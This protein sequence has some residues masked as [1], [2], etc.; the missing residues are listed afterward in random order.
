[1]LGSPSTAST[2]RAVESTRERGQSGTATD[3]TGI[4]RHRV[5]LFCVALLVCCT[6]L[7]VAPAEIATAD[8]DEHE[9]EYVVV[10]LADEHVVTESAADELP[11]G[12]S[13]H[14]TVGDSTER[15]VV[16]D[17]RVVTDQSGNEVRVG[18][19]TVRTVS[20]DPNLVV[21][22]DDV[23]NDTIRVNPSSGVVETVEGNSTVT[24]GGVEI[25]YTDYDE[26]YFVPEIESSDVNRPGEGENL[27]ATVDV[28]NWGYANGTKDV[29]LELF[30]GNNDLLG[31]VTEEIELD[32]GESTTQT[33]EY[34]T[35]RGDHEADEVIVSADG[36][37]SAT[38]DIDEA[39]TVVTILE[40][41]Q[42]AA[43]D[44]LEVTAD[45]QRLGNYPPGEQE[46][47]IEL[48][49][50]D[51]HVET[52][53]VGLNPGQNTTETF[54]YE[55]D[56]DDQPWVDI[57]LISGTDDDSTTVDVLGEASYNRSVMATIVDRNFPDEGENLTITGHVE[58]AGVVPDGPQE[59][60][61]KMYVDGELE[62]EQIVELDG[63]EI[64]ETDFT[65]Q[66]ESG[67]AP[68]VDVDLVSP[69]EDDSARP[70]VNGS[71]FDVAIQ[72]V[73][74]PVNATEEL[75]AT[76]LIENT[77]DIFGE[78]EI[79]MRI[80]RAI[81]NP[82]S[83]DRYIRDTE[84]VALNV[85]ERSVE[86]FSFRTRDADVSKVEVAIISEDDEDTV[87]ATVRGQEPH[88][89]VQDLAAEHT[90]D[91]ESELT[92]TADINNTGVESGEQYVELL[93]DGDAVHIER[94]SL[95]PW[96]ERT[97][98]TTID[99]PDG[100]GT[101]DFTAITENASDETTAAVTVTPAG[102]EGQAD[103]ESPSESTEA[104]ETNESADESSTAGPSEDDGL[105]WHL[106]GLGILGVAL[107]ALVLAA[108]RNDPDNFPPDA[109]T[110]KARAHSAITGAKARATALAIAVRNGDT[111][112]IL[113]ILKG[114]VGLG[115]G[116]LIVQNELPREAT[117]RVRCQTAEDTVL[118]EDLQIGPDEQHTLGSLP[119]ASQFKVGAG[120]EDITAHEEVFQGIS[121]DVGVVLRA[122]GILIA[123][124]G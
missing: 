13:P 20:A 47:L 2:S 45:I 74:S 33:F 31:E 73:N 54:T 65:Y 84:T 60:P 112:A 40:T 19:H 96:E 69:G 114:M 62:D 76:A 57:E 8:E 71:G 53:P 99:A 15:L 115:A 28:K 68:R 95:D 110:I 34:E 111:G 41:N 3:R 23:L 59:Y 49:V 72:E 85:N 66:T 51:S 27:T 98:E 89:D 55:T 113:S 42:P 18:D 94:L 50:D 1:M 122:D 70:R 44:E 91:P 9:D 29:T 63:D 97:I 25:E 14:V 5:V 35:V 120:V 109:A 107:A 58:Y 82:E 16:E 88:F 37:S 123:N 80:D 10:R 121:G 104:S 6:F 24:A 87:N 103:D 52:K 106:I 118:L 64:V 7:L 22:D 61:I 124:L 86:R 21:T 67:D 46:F 92:L 11:R 26:S 17:G 48:R 12:S 39:E 36:A 77:G 30:D 101:Y 4:G 119:D 90:N 108:Y 32:R 38:I 100:G 56:E 43:G 83:T 105:P 116:T 102:G 93:L 78:Q 79:R 81:D 75:I 117:V